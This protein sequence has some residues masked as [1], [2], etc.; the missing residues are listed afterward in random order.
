MTEK[1]AQA[2]WQRIRALFSAAMAL[3]ADERSAYLDAQCASDPELRAQVEALLA[4]ADVADADYA[5]VVQRVAADAAQDM[6]AVVGPYRLLQI[7]GEGGMG[8]VYLAERTDEQFEQR[9]AVKIL[10][11]RLPGKQLL[12]RFRAER[13]ILANLNHPNIASL[14]DGGETATGLPYLVMEYVAGVPLFE[15]ADRARLDL[16]DRLNM[17][18][19]VCDAVQH[20]H[21]NLVVHRDIKS[22]NIIV[23]DA[24]Q[25]KL[26]DFGIAKLLEP[27]GA[28]Y[29]VAE[30]VADARLL[31]PA[32][33]SPEQISGGQI[34]V[35][36]DI[37]QLGLLLYE[38]LSGQPAYA[39]DDLSPGELESVIRETQPKPPSTTAPDGV[40]RTLAGD[41]DTIVLKAL[42]KN[43]ARRYA[44]PREFADD[45]ERYLQ[46]RPVLARPD[47]RLYRIG[48][49]VRRNAL[50]TAATAAIAILTVAFVTTTYV[51]NR[52]I[53]TERDT[54]SAV[55]AFMIDIFN[56]ARPEESPGET[57]TARQ[58]L[59]SGYQ[60]IESELGD[61]PEVQARLLWVMG[62]S[63]TS[64]GLH[65][66]ALRLLGQAAELGRAGNLPDDDL[67]DVLANAAQEASYL[68]RFEE[69]GEYM[70]AAETVFA[71]IDD[72]DP[73]LGKIIYKHHANHLRR[74]GDI[75]AG[76]VKL[77][78][79]EAFARDIEDDPDGHYPDMLHELGAWNQIMGRY[80]ESVQWLRRALAHPH[81]S[82]SQPTSR[83][84][85]TLGVLGNTL[86]AQGKYSE[87]LTVMGEALVILQRE[88]GP[89]HIN[90]GITHGN[91]AAAQTQVGDLP[92]AEQHS[93]RAI[94]ITAAALGEDHSRMGIQLGGL[95]TIRERQGRYA[96]SLELF[97]RSL[98]IKRGSMPEG[99][100]SIGLAHHKLGVVHRALGNSGA[101]LQELDA[102]LAIFSA[103][104]GADS[105]RVANV[106]T[107]IGLTRI[108]TAEYALA[109]D[110]L[111]RAL[112]IYDEQPGSLQHARAHRAMAA[113]HAAGGNCDAAITS[114]AAAS[115][116]LDQ[117]DPQ[118][119]P[120]AD[121]L[122]EI[123]ASCGV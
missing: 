76:M 123:R 1:N 30:T 69:A 99:S 43:P 102:A 57:I 86:R 110:V 71:R 9:V 112:A 3:P 47:T 17:F 44:S 52:R 37:Y 8:R 13:Q 115:A 92:A 12:Q 10:S 6:P 121:A 65:E 16:R 78:R 29:T 5:S 113:L 46:H 111:K 22:S 51:Q 41:L 11:A 55:S 116:L 62:E 60:R 77:L 100:T 58:V 81:P 33:A 32:N 95:A 88:V 74:S 19:A 35:A 119:Q 61:Q 73:T 117:K 59:D 64:L 39:V 20:A 25:L 97:Q 83:R 4:S 120:E 50:G 27:S 87:A 94:E 54:A 105:Q 122:R 34:T 107:D 31:T 91:I 23:N 40:D 118:S 103:A 72:P 90:V 82:R 106:L 63:Y 96:E 98:A 15:Y 108:A 104:L 89:D 75:E 49:F 70:V 28:N 18:L 79:A 36:T 38:L 45:I 26:L 56:L 48:K 114:S 85:V 84:A 21:Q 2:E 80:D 93:L 24:G 67:V 7:L 42:R 101:S 66:D 109:E 53:A 68:D 14:L